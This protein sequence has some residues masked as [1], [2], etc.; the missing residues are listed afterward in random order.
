M[1]IIVMR[2]EHILN[3]A[4]LF[5]RCRMIWFSLLTSRSCLGGGFQFLMSIYLNKA[6]YCPATFKLKSNDT[7]LTKSFKVIGI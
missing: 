2:N 3:V 7:K 4:L 5:K 1:W 6:N